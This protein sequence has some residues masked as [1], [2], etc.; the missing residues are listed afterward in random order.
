MLVRGAAGKRVSA[1]RQIL[2]RSLSGATIN[3][4]QVVLFEL[5]TSIPVVVGPHYSA[6]DSVQTASGIET[7]VRLA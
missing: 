4:V 3:R 6:Q 1:P 2:R 5:Q 7:V